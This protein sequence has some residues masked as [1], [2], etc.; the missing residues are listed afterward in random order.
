[1]KSFVC[2][3]EGI[4]M[5]MVIAF[6]ALSVPMITGALALS[7]TL[8]RDSTVKTEILKRQYA[9]LGGDQW[10][11]YVIEEGLPPG[12]YP[13]ELNDD[14]TDVIVAA[15]PDLLYP[16]PPADNSRRLFSSMTVSAEI[17]NPPDPLDPDPTPSPFTYTVTVTNRDDEPEGLNKITAVLP[18]GFD[19]V[20][21]SSTIDGGFLNDPNIQGQKLTWNLSPMG[22][23]LLPATPTEEA[24]YKVITYVAEAILSND[25]NYC[26]EAWAVPGGTKTGTGL[27]ALIEVGNPGHDLCTGRAVSVQTSAEVMGGT[28]VGS[29]PIT[30]EYTIKIEN[31]GTQDLGLSKVRDL[32]S[33]GFIYSLGSTSGDV[34]LLDPSQTMIQGRQRLDWTFAPAVNIPAGEYREVK[35]KVEGPFAGGHWNDAWL[36]FNGFGNSIYTWPSAG[37]TVINVTESTTNTASGATVYSLIWQ[38]GPESFVLWEWEITM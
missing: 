3:Q 35:F 6:M 17:G 21:G 27:G 7:G 20:D 33:P 5:I 24:Q 36:T 32:L 1:M 30:T 12:D 13:I 22:I 14:P 11:N 9:A 26:A 28:V 2:R 8:S 34:T 38:I 31:K 37:I 16:P 25:S 29:N 4:A 18:P 15:L 10:G 23:T 19:Y